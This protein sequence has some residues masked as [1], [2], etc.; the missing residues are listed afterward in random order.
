MRP[1]LRPRPWRC[2]P[3]LAL[4][5]VF[6]LAMAPAGAWAADGALSPAQEKAVRALVRDTLL[7]QP[8]ILKEAFQILQ[9]REA[10][11]EAAHQA[12]VIRDLGDSLTR[13]EG[14]P[15]LGNPNGDVTIVEFSDYHCGYCK[16]AFP[17]LWDEVEAD[18]NIA[19]VVI[20][21]PILGPDS[22]M[23]ARAALAA[24]LQDPARYAPMHQA[25][26]AHK[27]EFTEE[28]IAAIAKEQ[29]LDADR[30]VK[31]MDAEAVT[32]R[33]GQNYQLA[34]ALGVSG[35]PAFVIGER[36]IPGAVPPDA[37]KRLVADARAAE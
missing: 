17:V 30:L 8:E 22:V 37:L 33:L 9:E 21:Y 24:T 31:D 7:G 26:M 19:L 12:A 5:L 10:E 28:V 25:L 11:A 36:M 6:G 18:G 1:S 16:R 34:Q 23:A 29:G 3:A 2:A 4:G 14:M 32:N 35:T 20:E 27:G 13:P 15:V